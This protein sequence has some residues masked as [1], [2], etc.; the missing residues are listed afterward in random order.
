V[1][2]TCDG[3]SNS[4]PADKKAPDNTSCSDGVFCNGAETC[5][6]GTCSPGTDPCPSEV[7]D[8]SSAM[9]LIAACSATPQAGCRTAQ[10]SMLLVKTKTGDPSK[11]KLLW[12]FIKGDTT[13][14]A[15]LGDPTTSA[16]YALCIYAGASQNLVGTLSISANAT[17]WSPVGTTKGYKYFD[18]GSATDGVQKIIVKASASNNTKEL[19]KAGGAT[20]PDILGP[21]GLDAPVTAQLINHGSGICWQGSFPMPL[22]NSATQFKGKQ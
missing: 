13:S 1:A 17:L 6:S 9:C 5:Q 15:D 11:S 8:E 19:L 20:L 22:K 16:S 2:D 7:C 4:C 18:S 21:M 10:K 14:F 12:K 3:S